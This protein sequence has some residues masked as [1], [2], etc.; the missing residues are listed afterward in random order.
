MQ[1]CFASLNVMS[2]LSY[3]GV[4]HSLANQNSICNHKHPCTKQWDVML[5]D[6]AGTKIIVSEEPVS[7]F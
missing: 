7:N 5:S 4:R 2:F 3:K 6:R 1:N